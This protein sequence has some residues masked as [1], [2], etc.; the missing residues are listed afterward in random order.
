[1]CIFFHLKTAQWRKFTF[2]GLS[3][4]IRVFTFLLNKRK[5]FSFLQSQAITTNVIKCIV[6]ARE[7]CSR[8]SI[9]T[10]RAVIT[11]HASLLSSSYWQR[12][13]VG[14]SYRILPHPRRFLLSKVFSLRSNFT[15]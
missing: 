7:T 2:P 12:A 14:K 13:M 10:E 3:H 4:K 15:L 11:A 6:V 9:A 8:Y 1:M 5:N